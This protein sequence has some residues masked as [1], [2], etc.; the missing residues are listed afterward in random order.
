MQ[1]LLSTTEYL[2]VIKQKSKVALFLSLFK[3]HT[4]QP[5]GKV[6]PDGCE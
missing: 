3:L 2:H 5:Y 6:V 1:L 4:K